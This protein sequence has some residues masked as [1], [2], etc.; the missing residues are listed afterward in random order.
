MEETEKVYD[1]EKAAKAQSKYCKERG[2][3]YYAPKGGGTC[4]QCRKNIYAP[5]K[6]EVRNQLGELTGGTKIS[7]IDVEKAGSQLITGCP[8]CGHSF[9][10]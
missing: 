9:V 1:I 8:H 2:I 4:W 10:D 5:I 6:Y 7:G 3:P